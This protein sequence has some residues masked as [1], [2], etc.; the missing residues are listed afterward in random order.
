MQPLAKMRTGLLNRAKHV[1]NLI[2]LICL[3]FGCAVDR[4]VTD[5]TA[6]PQEEANSRTVSRDVYDAIQCADCEQNFQRVELP[7]DYE[8]PT[9]DLSECLAY[10]LDQNPDSADLLMSGWMECV[11]AAPDAESCQ[12]GEHCNVAGVL[13]I[14]RTP[15]EFTAILNVGSGCV[16]LALPN[17]IYEDSTNWNDRRVLISGMAFASHRS[18][19]F[20]VTYELNGRN[21]TAGACG[22]SP[23]VIFVEKAS[24]F[25]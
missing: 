7:T 13:R 22:A 21:V 4:Q 17:S 18:D 19:E 25:E 6:A 11:E 2:F 1:A 23:Y 3:I 8:L 12:I 14:F 5:S 24:P 20:V 9:Q 16:P 15:P 10:V